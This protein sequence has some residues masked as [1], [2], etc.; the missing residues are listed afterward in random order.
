MRFLGEIAS[1]DL[2]VS[3]IR[4]IESFWDGELP[5]FDLDEVR[6]QP[7]LVANRG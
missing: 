3:P 2:D 7:C 6:M 4:T 1:L 5:V